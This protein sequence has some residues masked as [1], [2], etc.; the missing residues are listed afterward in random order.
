LRGK[1]FTLLSH[2]KNWGEDRVYF[3]DGAGRLKSLPASWTSLRPVDA[4]EAISG[5]RALFR[6]DDLLR[7]AD[8]LSDLESPA[9]GSAADDQELV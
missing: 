1:E 2:T 3:Y 4:F 5:G 9:V 8:L 7:L 6:P